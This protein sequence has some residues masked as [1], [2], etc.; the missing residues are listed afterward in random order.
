MALLD[1]R[2]NAS[3]DSLRACIFQALYL[4]SG[5]FLSQAYV[6]T[7]MAATTAI[8]L[9]LHVCDIQSRDR[10]KCTDETIFRRRQ[11][12]AVLYMR[13]VYLASALGRPNLLRDADAGQTLPCRQD[14]FY[15]E[16]RSF[17]R[18]NPQT[19]ESETLLAAK[20]IGAMARIS[21]GRYPSN[22]SMMLNSESTY[23]VDLG[24]LRTLE[25]GGC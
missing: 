8:G 23:N 24:E 14:K 21:F 12:F 1:L 17:A 16:G 13:H 5:P 20:M 4:A 7:C 10:P 19:P 22:R 11:T 25:T 15:D 9:G 6:R 3:L 2:D 18:D